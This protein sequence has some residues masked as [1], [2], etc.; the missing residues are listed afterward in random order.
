[1][2]VIEVIPLASLPPQVPQLLSYF[3]SK[4]LLK[5][6][7]VEILIGNRRTPPVVVSSVSLEE[8]K[9]SLKKSSFQLK[10]L[11]AVISEVP[12]VSNRQ[13]RIAVWLSRNYFT[14]LGLCL[15]T[16]LPSFFLKKNYKLQITNYKSENNQKSETIKPIVLLSRAKDTIKTVE[17][18][19]KKTLRKKKQVLVVVPEISM[20]GYFYDVLA[21]HYE[22]TVIHSKISSKKLYQN[23][24]SISSGD[25]EVLIGTRLALFA[26]FLSLGLVIIEDPANEAYRSDMSPKYNAL[27]L[28]AEVTRTYS[29]QL[30]MISGIPSMDEYYKIK[31][32][33]HYIRNDLKDLKPA[34]VSISNMLEEMKKGNFSVFSQESKRQIIKY[35]KSRKKIL[36]F[37]SRKGYFGSLVCENCSFTFKCPN[38]SI[39]FRLH[40]SPESLFIC[41]RCSAVQKPP[42]S[43]PNCRSYKLRPVGFPGSQ[44]LEEELNQILSNNS[45]KADIFVF[46]SSSIKTSKSE[47]EMLK[48]MEESNSS[49]CIATQ[50][51]FSHRYSKKFDL[52]LIPNL[53]SLTT[54]PDF[55][56]EEHLFYQFAKILDFEPESI[57]IQTYNSESPLISKLVSNNYDEFYDQEL[58]VRKIFWYPPF[59][60]LIKLSFRHPEHSKATYETRITSEKLKMAIA[61]M[62]LGESVKILDPSPAFVEKEKG[63]YTHNIILKIMPEQKADEILRFV[64][65]GWIIDV[66][67]KNIL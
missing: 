23:W 54:V 49:I 9:A 32:G 10:K 14:P 12:F 60:R 4:P 41:H 35:A 8:E 28:A 46:D 16:V 11:S 64:P 67:P 51:I 22:T 43:C 55:R 30:T 7:V 3:F 63:L 58:P 13:F 18:E 57:V 56:S 29:A 33:L 24:L 19:I 52:I 47:D 40:K 17:T 31:S 34:D 27:D 38:C 39:P 42:D 36:I 2:F 66:D 53:D 6:S 44:R 50:L 48:N 20:V 59:A 25:T 15:K 45:L 5:G 1:M 65:S 62:K 26:P 21:S 61:Q 37:S